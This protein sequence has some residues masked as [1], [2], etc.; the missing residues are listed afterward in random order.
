VS[1]GHGRI[2][3]RAHRHGRAVIAVATIPVFLAAACGG[4]RTDAVAAVQQAAD[5]ADQMMV[6]V[7]MYLTNL[8]VRQAYLEAD[9]AF[10][11]E[12]Q[13]RTELRRVRVTFFQQSG[14]Q[15]SVLTADEGTY[16]GRD[17]RME[18]RGNVVVVRADG[19]RLTTAVLRYDQER[20]EVSTDQPYT[21]ASAERN[22]TGVG[23]TS[24]PA[25]TTIRTQQVRGSGGQFTL[26]GQ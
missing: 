15:S 7:R 2:G 14:E 6:G 10:V 18:G 24:D 9:S 12:N 16:W 19:A 26:P 5:S 1:S 23:F 20:N 17:G 11:F 13:G 21:Y 8:G 4:E 3:A 25:F 22:V